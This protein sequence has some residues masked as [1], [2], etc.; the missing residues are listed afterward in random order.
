MIYDTERIEC[1][2][3]FF[4]IFPKDVINLI[5][6]YHV[7]YKEM[8]DKILKMGIK[9]KVPELFYFNN[10]T[11]PRLLSA[12][13][14]FSPTTFHDITKSIQELYGEKRNWNRRAHIVE[15]YEEFVGYNLRFTFEDYPTNYIIQTYID[16][17][18]HV[19]PIYIMPPSL[20]NRLYLGQDTIH[21]VD[22]L[23]D[24]H[25]TDINYAKII[26]GNHHSVISDGTI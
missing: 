10:W 8:F 17:F 20:Q 7:T 14:V 26:C 24:G 15:F 3:I 25:F 1:K 4:K 22:S 19:N 18:V 21:S 16:T 12:R 9:I 13:V 23:F 5:F 2:N 6:D 11:G